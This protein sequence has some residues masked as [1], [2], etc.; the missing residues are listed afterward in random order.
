MICRFVLRDW[1]IHK[2]E[3]ISQ[4]SKVYNILASVSRKNTFLIIS[5]EMREEILRNRIKKNLS[6]AYS[7]KYRN[8]VGMAFKIWRL[9]S[10]NKKIHEFT[11]SYGEEV[12]N[13]NYVSNKKESI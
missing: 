12:A 1:R 8:N 13:F 3:F 10:L 5:E 9:L 11:E 4:W 2:N 6:R 7:K